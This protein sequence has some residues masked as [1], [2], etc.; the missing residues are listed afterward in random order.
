MD[1]YK[2][3]ELYAKPF[4]SEY[5]CGETYESLDWFEINEQPKPTLDEL[6][7][8]H[9][10]YLIEKEKKRYLELRAAAYP[11][12]E[13]QLDTIYHF[14]LNT[15]RDQIKAVKDKYPEIEGQVS[16]KPIDKIEKKMENLEHNLEQLTRG[17]TVAE[18][19][20]QDVKE[21]ISNVDAAMIAIK[22]FMMEIP[23]LK[24]QLDDIQKTLSKI[25]GV[26]NANN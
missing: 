26:S 5:S 6:E 25:E 4:H 19:N 13:D 18:A 9:K 17:L 24:I 15:W 21:I 1:L 14:G 3:L 7:R 10:L 2:A 20:S 23:N 22:G 11:K 8:L 12:I 16:I